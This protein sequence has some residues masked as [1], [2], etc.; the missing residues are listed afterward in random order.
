MPPNHLILCY[1][2]FSCPQS[3]PA[4]GSFPMSRLFPSG[5]QS[6][7]V[8][9]SASVLPMNIQSW[10]PLGWTGWISL[11]S[12]G[13]SLAPQFE[14]INASGLSLL[15]GPTLTSLHDSWINHRSPQLIPSCRLAQL[16]SS[17]WYPH[18][19][20]RGTGTTAHGSGCCNLLLPT[21]P[22]LSLPQATELYKQERALEIWSPSDSNVCLTW[23]LH[24]KSAT[25]WYQMSLQVTG[26]PSGNLNVPYIPG[27]GS[28]LLFLSSKTPIHHLWC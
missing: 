2:F 26:A 16:L 6:I 15:Y 19:W 5:G 8:S 14:S 23:R 10:F 18:G 11:Q 25:S 4:S 28:K 13:L 22:L 20:T 7:G 17:L 21:P 1:P 12:K 3:F 9:A 27:W 24:I